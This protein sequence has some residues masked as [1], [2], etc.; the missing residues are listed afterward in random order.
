MWAFGQI[1]L[2]GRLFASALHPLQLQKKY[3]DE[4]YINPKNVCVN[5]ALGVINMI[6]F[7]VY[8]SKLSPLVCSIKQ[9]V[10]F[11]VFALGYC[12]SCVFGLIGLVCSCWGKTLVG[13]LLNEY[14]NWF[15][16]RGFLFLCGLFMVFIS[17]TWWC[18]WNLEII[19]YN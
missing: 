12:M 8:P 5:Y 6:L 3:Y 7:K 18:T 19:T 10:W 16:F 4:L 9:G 1:R 13:I 15:L 11:C 17:Q 2:S 14:E